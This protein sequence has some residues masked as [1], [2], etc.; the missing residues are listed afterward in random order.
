MVKVSLRNL[1][2]NKLRLFLTVTA[3]TVGVAFVSGTFVLSDTMVKAFDELYTGLSAGTDVVVKSEPAFEADVTTNGGAVRPLDE[4]M[5]ATVAGVP[6]VEVAQGSVFGFAIIIDEDGEPIQPG[7]APTFGTSVGGDERL[8]GDVSFRDGRAPSGPDEMAI[9]ARTVETAGFVLGDSVDVV[10]EEGRGTFTLVGVVGFG[11]TDSIL[12]ATLAGFDLPTAQSVLGREGVVDEVDVLAEDGVSATEL[13]D[14]I[15]EVLPEG[16]EALTGE[17]VAEDGTAAVEDA[18]GIFT[19]VLL[20]FAGVAL[21]V[22]S[23]VIWNTFNVLV[24]QRRREVALLRAVGASRRQVL[25]GVLVEAGCIGF[26]SGVIGILAGVGMAIGIRSLL[27][28]IGIEM[29]TT[30]PAVETRTVLVGMTVGLVVTVVAAVLPA[31]SAAR[32][33]PMEAL[34][35]VVPTLPGSPRL[36]HAAGWALMVAGAAGLVWCSVV[37]NQRWGTVVASLVAFVG[38]LFVGPSL[39]RGMARLVDHGRRGSGWRMAARNIGRNSRRAAATAMALTIGLTVVSA[40]AVTASSLKDSVTEAV[41][42]GNR[43]D[44]ILEPYG[45][46]L[47]VSPAVAD[48][49]RAREDVADV[50]ELRETGAQVDG[51]NSLVTGLTADGLDQVIDLGIETGSLDAFEP[52]HLLVSTSNAE[53]LG[54]EVGDPVTVTFAETGSSTMEVAGTFSKGSL[55]NA[56]YVMTLPDFAANVTSKLDG[57]ILMT[58]APGV[59]PDD[60]KATIEKAVA[61]YPNVEVNNPAD[62]TADARASVDQLLGIVTALL[63]LAVVVAILGIVNT[64]VLSV[65]QRTRELGLLRAVGGTRRQVKAVIRRESVLMSLLGALTGVGLGTLAGVALSRA[66]ADEG[67]TTISVPT[68]TLAIYLLVAVAVGLLA[69]LGPARRASRVDVLKAITTE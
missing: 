39:A 27:T 12:G 33:S 9:D 63:L 40:V 41:S 48:L 54:L 32:V 10:F 56:T 19:T 24:A 67:I 4:E 60:A 15:G 66:L 62:I 59:D 28:L 46:G 36:R 45:V 69:A 49:L 57:A 22:G 58:N 21:L 65:V 64:L 25:T 3:V 8:A 16:V 52:G 23:F 38:L 5:V 42:G 61:D 30:S 43:S 2:V 53:E 7:G 29:P 44:L 13:R 31:W 18:M 68:T 26:V 1:L 35:D 55:I 47:G 50:V 14:R 17:Q 51:H 34:R 20:V 37:G 6:G 11:E